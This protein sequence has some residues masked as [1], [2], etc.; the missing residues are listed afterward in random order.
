MHFAQT[1]HASIA[2]VP[3]PLHLSVPPPLPHLLFASSASSAHESRLSCGLHRHLHSAAANHKADSPQRR[4]TTLTLYARRLVSCLPP[5][6][7]PAQL[8]EEVFLSAVTSI[9]SGK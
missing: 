7:L 4:L 9:T 8:E 6:Q 5:Q 2:S 3:K 1:P